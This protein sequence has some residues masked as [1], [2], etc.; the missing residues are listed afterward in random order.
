VKRGP[1]RRA[2]LVAAAASPLGGCAV[3]PTVYDRAAADG[4]WPADHVAVLGRIDL[5]PPIEADEQQ[6]RP[7]ALDLFGHEEKLRN[8][9]AL[10]LSE[11]DVV[12]RE[13]TANVL[14]PPLGDWFCIA[15]PRRLQV[16]SDAVVFMESSVRTISRRQATV[17]TTELLLPAPVRLG[18][19]PT[20][21]VV[22]IGNWTVWRDEF[23]SVTRFRVADASVEARRVL[24]GR[25]G[26]RQAMRTLVPRRGD[27][28]TAI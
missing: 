4:R 12:R 7:G 3:I 13:R 8:R 18:F 17:D 2:V 21:N 23:H 16:V 15:V 26:I 22:Y 6:I 11:A 9:A 28:A 5:I 25:F 1:T 27:H 24:G 19:E 20:D 10:F 14:N